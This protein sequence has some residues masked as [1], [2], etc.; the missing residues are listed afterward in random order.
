MSEEKTENLFSYGTLQSE[1]VHL[2]TFGRA[3]AGAADLLPGYAL[4]LVEIDDPQVVATSGATH[5]PIVRYTGSPAD[6]VPGTVFQITTDELQ[7]SDEYEVGAY[8]RTSVVLVSGLPALVYVS[9]TG[10][11]V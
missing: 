2:A 5:H 8:V 7:Q 6:T 4:S 1:H 3:L 11:K 9:A 10:G